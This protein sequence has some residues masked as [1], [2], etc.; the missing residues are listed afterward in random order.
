[1]GANRHISLFHPSL[2][3]YGW[4]HGLAGVLFFKGDMP[5][6]Y[7]VLVRTVRL[8]VD[9]ETGVQHAV[10]W[11]EGNGWEVIQVHRVIDLP[12]TVVLV[13]DLGPGMED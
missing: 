13:L 10:D 2:L 5:H 1:M 4:T 6:K 8:Q 12:L 11:Y 9:N 7:S 3:T